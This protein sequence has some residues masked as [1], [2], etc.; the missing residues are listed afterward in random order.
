[1]PYDE[2]EAIQKRMEEFNAYRKS[3]QPPGAS[4]GSIFKNPEGD[5]AGRLIEASGLKAYHIGGVEVSQKHAN[6]F[7]VHDGDHATA[8]DYYRL[9]RHVQETV[10]AKQ[11]IKL[12]LEIELVGE[13]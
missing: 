9:I 11:G 13:W 2:P 8:S 12:E 3:T 7:V 5:Y 1:L 6:F 10:M 4:L